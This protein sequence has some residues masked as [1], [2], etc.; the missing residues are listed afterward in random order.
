MIREGVIGRCR[1]RRNY[2]T[3]QRKVE[4]GS[5][6]KDHKTKKGHEVEKDL[7]R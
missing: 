1:V 4:C 6:K 3:L 7:E 2:K 5:E